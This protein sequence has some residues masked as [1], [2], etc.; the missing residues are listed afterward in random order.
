MVEQHLEHLKKFSGSQ[1]KV[2]LADALNDQAFQRLVMAALDPAT[3]YGVKGN[4]KYGYGHEAFG[5]PAHRLLEQLASRTLTGNAAKE[6]LN[7]FCQLHTQAAVETLNKVLNKDLRCGVGVKAVNELRRADFSIPVFTCALAQPG[8]AKRLRTGRQ[9]AASIK[10]DGMRTLIEVN[11]NRVAFWTRSGKAIPKLQPMESA[12]LEVFGGHKLM[13]DSEGVGADFLATM[14]QLRG[15]TA[16]ANV[17]HTT[18]L[19]LFDILDLADFRKYFG[20]DQPFGGP[21]RDRLGRLAGFFQAPPPRP[22]K[23]V[24]H[25]HIGDDWGKAQALAD[26]WMA[27][28]LEGAILRNLD[29]QYTKERTYDWLKIKL[30]DTVDTLITG[31]YE[32]EAGTKY[33]GMLGGV[34]VIVNGVASDV[35]GGWSDWERAAVWAAETGQPVAYTYVTRDYDPDAG[36]GPSYEVTETVQPEAANRVKGRLLEV[37]FNG[38]MPSGALRHGRKVKFRD[39]EGAKA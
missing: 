32:G 7:D 14:S 5:E 31:V 19:Q 21:L 36:Y 17:I 18:D 38:Y 3:T 33:E 2:Q 29:A 1:L 25:H 34:N 11:D 13:L 4:L 9:W 28:Q 12:V 23:Q 8:E 35:G 10:Y 15:K 22:I 24:T 26:E 27:Q 16:D 37:L 39:V 30:E 20:R 6:A